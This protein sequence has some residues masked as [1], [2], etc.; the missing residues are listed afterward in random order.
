MTNPD[1]CTIG[2]RIFAK[3]RRPDPEQVKRLSAA[4]VGDISDVMRGMGVVDSV[5]TAVYSPMGRIFGPA[6][7]VDLSPGD[8]L[9][10]R[11]AIQYSEPGDVVIANAHGVVE[12]A[13]LGGV[14][15]MHM[16]HRGIRGLVVDGAVRDV[17]EF[18][19]LGLPVMARAI[20]PRSGTSSSGWGEV[21]VPVACGG[22]V[23]HPGDLVVGDDE[24]LVIVPHRWVE[25]V[26]NNL[27][28]AGH[29]S[30]APESMRDR[31]SKLAPDAP[32]LG[33]DRVHKALAERAGV[34][35]DGTFEDGDGPVATKRL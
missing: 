24:G 20:T 11:A 8:G 10:L 19:G 32:I 17:E 13:V 23:V 2:L 22:A 1:K 9:L 33:M 3:V 25:S 12:R 30:Y 18:R 29:P 31:L 15:G 21:N 34:I 6:V 28:D 7:T 5:I 35:I 27:G 16:V 4:S 14:I 26:A